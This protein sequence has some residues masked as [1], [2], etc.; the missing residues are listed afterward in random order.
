MSCSLV[1]LVVALYSVKNGWLTLSRVEAHQ[2]ASGYLGFNVRKWSSPRNSLA[3]IG[4]LWRR[5]CGR[6]CCASSGEKMEGQFWIFG[7]GTT[8]RGLEGLSTQLGGLLHNSRFQQAKS[9]Q[10]YWRKLTAKLMWRLRRG[11][12][13]ESIAFFLENWCFFNLIAPDMTLVL[14]LQLW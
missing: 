5:Y 1:N 12:N 11:W 2:T 10:T 7:L 4:F 8:S 13:C 9:R 14:P 6:R 3:F